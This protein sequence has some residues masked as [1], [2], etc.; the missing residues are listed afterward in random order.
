ML[1][2]GTET[3]PQPRTL[4]TVLVITLEG[5]SPFPVAIFQNFGLCT[6]LN[7]KLVFERR[8]KTPSEKCSQKCPSR[9]WLFSSPSSAS[10]P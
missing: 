1:N 4:G 10:T 6:F 7:Q 8:E 2:T 9:L 3:A 5:E